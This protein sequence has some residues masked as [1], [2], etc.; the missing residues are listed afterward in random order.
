MILEVAQLSIKA[1]QEAEFEAIFP[2]AA[3]VIA[4][5]RGYI[6]HE[7]QRGIESPS[8]YVLLVQWQTLE[9]H[10]AGFRGSP[11]FAEWRGHIGKF[12]ESAPVVEHYQ[13]PFHGTR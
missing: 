9:D 12:F 5:A 7:I 8:R 6:A 4:A 10:T 3:K 13:A 2:A 11:A 1:G